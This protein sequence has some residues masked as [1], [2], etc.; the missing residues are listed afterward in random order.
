MVKLSNDRAL[1]S[2][3]VPQ[4]YDQKVELNGGSNSV[5]ID[6]SKAQRYEANPDCDFAGY[7]SNGGNEFCTLYIAVECQE[8]ED[9]CAF[10]VSLQL[11][12]FTSDGS[13]GKPV[14]AKPA[15][16]VPNDQ[17]Y[18]DVTVP[19]VKTA[20]FYY[21]VVPEVSGDLLIFVNKTA[22]IG[23][24][25]DA[26]LLLNVQ[27]NSENSYLSWPYARSDYYTIAS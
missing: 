17:D 23:Q 6:L 15:R 14:T 3:A 8:L 20:R 16:Y 18:V 26:A 22:S 21:P 12:E 1:P 9:M 25:G 2:S 13:L 11:F 24:G 7:W 27:K 10:K 4:S 5:H 19:Y